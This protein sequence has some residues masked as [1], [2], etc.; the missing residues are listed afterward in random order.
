MG[1]GTN[2]T[3]GSGEHQNGRRAMEDLIRRQRE[4]GIPAAKAEQTARESAKRMDRTNN[5]RK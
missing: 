1:D 3:Q 4:M 5:G 2:T